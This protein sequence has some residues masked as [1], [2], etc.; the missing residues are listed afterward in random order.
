M[1][2]EV[3]AWTQYARSVEITSERSRVSVYQDIDI[4]TLETGKAGIN[5]WAAMGTQSV[6]TT[7]DFV[8]ML[9]LAIDIAAEIELISEWSMDS[10]PTNL[11]DLV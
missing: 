11:G 2:V 8:A 9:D 1:K 4:K 6:Q 10:K 3:R 7:K 5:W